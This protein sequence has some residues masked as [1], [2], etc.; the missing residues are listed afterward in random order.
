MRKGIPQIYGTQGVWN[1][2]RKLMEL[3]KI[4]SFKTI[5]SIRAEYG[6]GKLSKYLK[7]AE[8]ALPQW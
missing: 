4:Q 8:M 7:M 5:D 2:K 3:Y 6:L 1:P